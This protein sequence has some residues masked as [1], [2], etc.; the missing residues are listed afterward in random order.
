MFGSD[1][2]HTTGHPNDQLLDTL[3]ADDADNVRHANAAAWY[4]F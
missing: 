2:P 1:Y 4:S 3:D